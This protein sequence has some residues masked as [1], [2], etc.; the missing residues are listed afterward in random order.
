MILRHLLREAKDQVP[1]MIRGAVEHKLKHAAIYY[2]YHRQAA[3]HYRR[4]A[5]DARRSGK[6][7]AARWY[8][9]RAWF[10]RQRRRKFR[11]LVEAKDKAGQ[12]A[13]V[14]SC[15]DA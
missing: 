1:G 12:C 15:L 7:S 8:E 14:L 5:G 13:G 11:R 10:H 9:A 4:V 6:N 2:Y 3:T